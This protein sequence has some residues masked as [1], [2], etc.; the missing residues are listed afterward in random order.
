M[1]RRQAADHQPQQHQ[2]PAV[3]RPAGTRRAARRARPT[4]ADDHQETAV[5]GDLILGLVEHLEDPAAE[6]DRGRTGRAPRGPHQAEQRAADGEQ[7]DDDTGR[8]EIVA[9][10]RSRWCLDPER[11]PAGSPR[12]GSARTAAPPSAALFHSRCSS[13]TRAG[14]TTRSMSK[15]RSRDERVLAAA[16][17]QPHGQPRQRQ[18]APG[19]TEAAQF[20]QHVAA[21]VLDERVHPVLGRAVAARPP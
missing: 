15:P 2:R 19:Q 8:Q 10:R 1:P 3:A 6:N 20:A 14:G 13:S 18:A 4:H 12:R 16:A 21:G 7:A 11:G 17:E 5:A 9:G